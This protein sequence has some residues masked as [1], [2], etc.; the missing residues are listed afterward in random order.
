MKMYTDD[1]RSN[2]ERKDL[3]TMGESLYKRYF[4]SY[5]GKWCARELSNS[6]VQ[7]TVCIREIVVVGDISE[8]EHIFVLTKIGNRYIVCVTSEV[9]TMQEKINHFL[10]FR[11]GR[12]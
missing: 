3:W 6:T 4:Y 9:Q 1:R 10:D 12:Q 5:L 7:V 2:W 11:L 8:V